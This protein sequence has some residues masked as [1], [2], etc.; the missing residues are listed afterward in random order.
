MTGR[1][2][3]NRFEKILSGSNEYY[4]RRHDAAGAGMIS[5]KYLV[6]CV[7]ILIMHYDI[8]VCNIIVATW[9]ETRLLIKFIERIW[10]DRVLIDL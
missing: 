2:S 4:I 5:S 7:L 6:L 8:T 10:N 1:E 9:M 3:N